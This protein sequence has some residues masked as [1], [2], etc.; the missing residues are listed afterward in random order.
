MNIKVRTNISNVFQKIEVCINAPEI[1]E[2]V[3]RLEIQF[4]TKV[5]KSF[6]K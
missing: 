4:L 2:E 6:I 1:Y 5:S 3:Q